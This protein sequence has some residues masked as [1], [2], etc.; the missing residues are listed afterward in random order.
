LNGGVET[1]ENSGSVLIFIIVAMF[2]I[3]GVPF[4]GVTEGKKVYGA[5]PHLMF[6]LSQKF[7]TKQHPPPCP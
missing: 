4:I 2:V 7:H 1:L 6:V 5:P 3:G